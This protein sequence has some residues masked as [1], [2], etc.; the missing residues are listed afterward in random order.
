MD[1]VIGQVV[2]VMRGL[3]DLG[4][5]GRPGVVGARGGLVAVLGG[6]GV[7]AAGVLVLPHALLVAALPR[8]LAWCV[9]RREWGLS[10]SIAFLLSLS[11]C[12]QIYLA[13]LFSFSHV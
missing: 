8:L 11:S 10:S 12:S 6:G 1:V 7:A 13:L 5:L 4:Q 2:V 9:L 3:D